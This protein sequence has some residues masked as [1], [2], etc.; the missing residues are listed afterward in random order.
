MCGFF[1]AITPQRLSDGKVSRATR[2]IQRRGPDKNQVYRAI[3]DNNQ[4]LVSSHY[5]LNVSGQT[6]LQP[7]IV[8]DQSN[9]P[10]YLILF[11]G[12]IYNYRGLSTSANSDTEVL[13]QLLEAKGLIPFDKI[14]GEYAIL[15]YDFVHN[16][17]TIATDQ[18][19]TKPVYVGWS[20]DGSVFGVASYPSAL[21][22]IGATKVAY[23]TPNSVINFEIANPSEW[24]LPAASPG[25]DSETYHYSLVQHVNH[26]DLW[27][28]RFLQS[29]S[30]RAKHGSLP[31]FVPLSS[32][33]DSGA[34]C[35][36]L[37]ILR[38]DYRT[39]TINSA[40][41]Q[42]ILARRLEINSSESG[43]CVEHILLPPLSAQECESIR[44]MIK[45]NCQPFE[46]IHSNQT[47]LDDD[48][49]IGA[50]RV[51]ETAR[52]RGW[53]VCL[54]GCGADEIISDYGFDGTK[55]Y[56][57]SQFGGLFPESLHGFFPW[58]KF[59]AD[60]MRSYLFKDEL[61]FGV[62]GIEG[63]YPFLDQQLTQEF[64]SLAAPLKNRAYK[65]PIMHFL[66]KYSYPFEPGAKRGFSPQAP[67]VQ[68]RRRRLIQWLSAKL[69]I[70]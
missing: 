31:I 42:L 34:I 64:L 56:P 68:S 12:E 41:N 53:Q 50:F 11:N 1:F 8:S 44:C 33:Y 21:E 62:F 46:F 18:F 25:I 35:L 28:E 65:A 40:E 17:V 26:Y 10:I 66:E 6:A 29:V 49:S 69:G 27:E 43:S 16:R 7:I 58:G 67:A 60:T 4:H 51:A 9:K 15:I 59:Y 39:I 30:K 32:G 63:R 70:D 45:R 13:S 55:H 61:I 36:A 37:N 2:F 14:D 48:G 47:L 38:I 54:S 5:L 23:S 52:R 24:S 19:M 3:V 22:A 57:H 20:L